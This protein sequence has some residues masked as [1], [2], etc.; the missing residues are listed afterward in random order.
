MR[1][2]LRRVSDG[3][4]DDGPLSAILK[5]EDNKVVSKQGRPE[6]GY[7]MQ[8]GSIYARTYQMQ[9]YWQTTEIT[10][11]TKDTENEVHFRTRNSEYI[12]TQF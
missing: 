7:W 6:V 9:D 5:V 12:W 1:Y 4:G 10:E 3:A 8:V 11:I 2:S